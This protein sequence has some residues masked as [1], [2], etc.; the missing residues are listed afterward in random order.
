L[1]ELAR[2]AARGSLPVVIEGETGTGKELLAR[3][4]HAWSGRTGPFVA[5]NCAALP[6]SL[7]EGELFGYRKGAFTGAERSSLGHFRAANGGT[8][9]LDEIVEMPVALQAKVLR[10]LEEREVLPL[11]ESNPVAVDVEVV[12]AAQCPLR[13]AVNDKRFR[14]DLLARLAGL[15]LTLPA[16]RERR[17]EIPFLFSRMLTEYAGGPPPAVE[18][19]LIERL[20]V[21]DW[22]LNLR[23]LDLLARRLMTLHGHEPMLRRSHLPREVT[24]RAEVSELSMGHAPADDRELSPK[25]RDRRDLNALLIALR[26]H[27]GNVARASAAIHIT[28]QRAYRL[29]EG[30]PEVLQEL[31]DGEATSDRSNPGLRS[32][33]S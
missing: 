30:S 8:I 24:I 16:L 17:E 26:K 15:T 18:P 25:Q 6:E 19:R 3:A 23:Q 29:M 4:I 14:G 22:P 28:R 20:C 27:H 5:V 31:R 1:A 10:V 33:A 2:R 7:A 13:Q 11:G 9:L 12:A 32:G 21:Y